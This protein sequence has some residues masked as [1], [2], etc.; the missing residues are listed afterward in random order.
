M[1]GSSICLMVAV[2]ALG[3]DESGNANGVPMTG[4][5]CSGDACEWPGGSMEGW[6]EG[7]G[8][9]ETWDREHGTTGGEGEGHAGG[10]GGGDGDGAY[11]GAD[12]GVGYGD[13]EGEGG[14]YGGGAGGAGGAVGGE[15]GEG[16]EEWA[17]PPEQEALEGG[18][19]DD[20]MLFDDYLEYTAEFLQTF[21]DDPMVHWLD[22]GRRHFVHVVDAQGRSVPDATIVL[23]A[24]D[25]AIAGRTRADGRY[26]FFPD[27]HDGADAYTVQVGSLVSRTS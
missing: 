6:E 15:G 27:A 2:V 22:I 12:A 24:G 5:A 3:C 9:R 23:S 21:G 19:I 10:G 25:E 11:A 18:E 1:R 26:A 7:D 8:V 16:E 4:A 17:P 14:E 20:N 13:E